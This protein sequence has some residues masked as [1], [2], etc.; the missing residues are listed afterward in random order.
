MH[1]APHVSSMKNHI[2]ARF[3]WFIIRL[4]A[5][6]AVTPVRVTRLEVY[7]FAQMD[8]LRRQDEQSRMFDVNRPSE[9]PTV[10]GEFDE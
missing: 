6:Q 7:G 4:A 5:G 1:D 9:P 10:P 8:D 3:C 2:K